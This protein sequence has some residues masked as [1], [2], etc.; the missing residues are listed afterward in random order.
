MINQLKELGLESS[1]DLYLKL[2][3]ASPDGV[4]VTDLTGKIFYVSQKAFELF[5]GNSAEEAKN[6]NV[7]DWIA[8]DYREAAVRNIQMVLAGQKAESNE[9]LL[10]GRNGRS[11]FGA[12]NS[13]ALKNQDGE[14]VGMVSIIRDITHTKKI[15]EKL[16]SSE[17]KYR[18]LFE[19]NPIPMWVYDVDTLK[20]IS[21]NNAAILS[22]GY[23]L[24]EFLNMTLKDI[25]P[26]E[27][28]PRLLENI[29]TDFREFQ[30]SNTWKHRKKDGTIIEVEIRSHAVI[31]DDF[32]ARLVM[33]V[34]VTERLKVERE[35]QNINRE[36]EHA[37]DVAEASDRLKSSLLMNIS[38]EFRTPMTAI[39]GFS[40]LIASE[41][42]DAD[43]QEQ[44]RRIS[45]AGSRLLKTL[46]DIMEMSQL[47]AGLVKEKY[48][49]I[50]I[51]SE[52]ARITIPYKNRAIS[53][54]IT[55]SFN[56]KTEGW[57]RVSPYFLEKAL[58][59][60]LDNSVKF[61]PFGS[62]EVH[63]D[64]L[65]KNERQHVLVKIID[66]GIGISPA[67][68]GAIFE[69]FRQASEGYGRS[70]E[71][72]GL[73][74]T[75]ARRMIELMGGAINLTSCPGCGTTVE[76]SF[77][78]HLKEPYKQNLQHSAVAESSIQTGGEKARLS[79][80]IVEDNVENV[81]LM[82]H[83]IRDICKPDIAYN[84]PAALKMAEQ[85]L[86]DLVFMDI[87]LGHDMDGLMCTRKL[88][89]MP[90]YKSVP[91]I[92]LTGYTLPGDKEQI[93]GAGCTHYIGKPF[94]RED[95]H[96]V[97]ATYVS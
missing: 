37:R 63:V 10:I 15:E 9:Y 54:G 48:S 14:T 41:S 59:H 51:S 44:A 80:L 61:T 69:A 72:I 76:I 67:E 27:E 88:R 62:I 78:G 30:N 64:T 94:A 18:L 31:F 77:P 20:F 91:I 50:D 84:G 52:L 40:E 1:L 58:G 56:P 96:E 21:V 47:D 90:S 87:N 45:K 49:L 75:I 74:L 8:P 86:Y 24:D 13:T 85:K 55:F 65:I 26:E 29:R 5:G 68:S 57:V 95:I 92:A 34:D 16:R 3:D 36:L 46:E 89:E 43:A 22:Y 73:G 53:R 6:S 42:F 70:Y 97:I 23:S 32:N 66:T 79:I 83:Y 25:R 93:I 39:L 28:V 33:A 38:H 81:L 7:I 11:L 2:I 35:M 4:V 12:I 17:A 82:S 19:S 60:I 71:G